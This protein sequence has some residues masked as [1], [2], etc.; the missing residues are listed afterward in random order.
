MRLLRPRPSVCRLLGIGGP[1]TVP[2]GVWTIVVDAIDRMIRRWAQTHVLK[3]ARE[4]TTPLCAYRDVASA[5]VGI[6]FIVGVVAA[7]LDVVP[8]VTLWRGPSIHVVAVL[9]I[10]GT[11]LLAHQ[12]ATASRAAIEQTGRL[13]GDFRSAIT[14][15]QP[16]R[17]TR[18]VRR[19][20]VACVAENHKPT[21]SFSGQINQLHRPYFNTPEAA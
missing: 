9:Q 15:T 11:L 20:A 18:A 10:A 21:Y 2:L 7:C 1:S 13:H 6:V 8:T 5:V 17:S 16:Q 4:R 19:D 3:K 12:A 14:A